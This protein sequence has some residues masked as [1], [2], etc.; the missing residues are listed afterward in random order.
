MQREY[1][2]GE[3][4][5]DQPRIMIATFRYSDDKYRIYSGRYKLRENGICVS[6]D[7]TRRQRKKLKDLKVTFSRVKY[8]LK[9]RQ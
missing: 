8:M 7:L 5:D 2:V 1:Q 3:P 4:K 6:D 9:G